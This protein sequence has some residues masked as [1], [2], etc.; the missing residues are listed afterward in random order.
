MMRAALVHATLGVWLGVGFQLMAKESWNNP[1]KRAE[2]DVRHE[3]FR[4]AALKNGVGYNI[5]LP[6][7]YSS[8]L[9]FSR[10]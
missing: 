6:P 10:A 7:E 8:K 9:M 4:S 3:T 1:P 5:C 2:R